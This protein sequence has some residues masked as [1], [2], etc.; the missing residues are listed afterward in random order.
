MTDPFFKETV[1]VM[2]EITPMWRTR[3]M[4]TIMQWL[5]EPC[6]LKKPMCFKIR[7]DTPDDMQAML[8]L[9]QHN[10][11]GVPAAIQQEDDRSL[12]LSDVD[13]WMWLKVI[14]PTKGVMMRQQLMLLFSEASQWASL[15][16]VSELPAPH[17][18]ELC[19]SAWTEYKSRSQPSVDMLLKDLAIWLGKQAGVM[20]THAAKLEEYAV[21]ALAKMAHSSA[22]QLAKRLHE[23]AQT[24]DHLDHWKQWLVESTKL[25]SELLVITPTNQPSSTASPAVSP[26]PYNPEG[27]STEMWPALAPYSDSNIHMGNVNDSVTDNLY[28]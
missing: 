19:N 9:W 20:L 13:I 23:M 1:E 11:E 28:Q 24:K 3:D 12:N 4:H 6:Q 22:S 8:S 18:S 15:V 14:T 27:G 16:D 5:C 26:P 7:E 10:L 2:M 17:S 21:H 25:D